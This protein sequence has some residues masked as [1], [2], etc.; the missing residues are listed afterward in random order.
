[1][2]VGERGQDLDHVGDRL[3][4]RDHVGGAAGLP[5]GGEDLLEALTPDV[6]HDD[7]AGVLVLDEVEDLDDVRVLDLGEEPPLGERGRHRV[8]VAGA[9]QALEHDPAV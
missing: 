6:L 7:V 2:Q 3:V 1:M 8:L 4:D 9:E 5:P